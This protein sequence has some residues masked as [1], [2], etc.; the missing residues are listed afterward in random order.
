MKKLVAILLLITV[1]LAC[2]VRT[3]PNKTH[4]DQR[5]WKIDEI[6]RSNE[7]IHRISADVKISSS[8][9]II[10]TIALMKP[11]YFHL[12]VQGKEIGTDI[13]FNHNHYWYKLKNTPNTYY[14]TYA[15][16]PFRPMPLNPCWIASCF[17][18]TKYK[19]D[20]LLSNDNW[21]AS[22]SVDGTI[23]S[24]TIF[25]R[26]IDKVLGFI[27]YDEHNKLI[28]HVAILKTIV[29]D[30]VCLPQKMKITCP[31]HDIDIVLVVSNY[32]I[33]VM[34]DPKEWEMPLFG[35]PQ[36]IP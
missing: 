9:K 23:T 27:F 13:G 12:K 36:F 6:N 4:I 8:D 10:G 24:A 30:D 11:D 34:I 32:R 15:S 2:L 19:T 16:C 17:G 29:I 35:N 18:N 33:N 20:T 3:P 5:I 25:N 1:I 7:S 26:Q 21:V 22:V 14:G 28:M 31:E